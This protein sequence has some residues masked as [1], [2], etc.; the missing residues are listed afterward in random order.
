MIYSVPHVSTLTYSELSY[1]DW[2]MYTLI[3]YMYTLHLL[4][5]HPLSTSKDKSLTLGSAGSIEQKDS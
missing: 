2:Y 4:D 3:Q 1:G 5:V